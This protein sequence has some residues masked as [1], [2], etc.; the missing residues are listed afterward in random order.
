MQARDKSHN[1]WKN[2]PAEDMELE[3]RKGVSL[4]ALLT[5]NHFCPNQLG[6]LC[7]N[8][9]NVSKKSKF[10]T[11]PLTLESSSSALESS[12]KEFSI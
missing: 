6:Q 9:K 1:S 2:Q 10:S 11:T 3:L 8:R 4:I 7:K 12:M 5:R